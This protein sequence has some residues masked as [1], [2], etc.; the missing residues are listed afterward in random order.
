MNLSRALL[1]ALMASLLGPLVARAEGPSVLP[2]VEGWEG[3]G[4]WRVS[5]GLL[6]GSAVA[7]EVGMPLGVFV[8]GLRR[9]GES[10][11]LLGLRVGFT[12]STE[13]NEAWVLRHEHFIGAAV[14]RVEH[15]QGP[16]L[17]YGQLAAGLMPVS[18]RAR[19][20]QFE[21]L[22]GLGLEDVERSSW[23]VGTWASLE[24]GLAVRIR[25]GLSASVGGGPTLTV[26]KVS[27]L[28]K[29]RWGFQTTLGVSHA[30]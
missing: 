1:I 2:G 30:F 14:A 29:M 6:W 26:Q 16:G 23:S 28:D 19:R 10:P 7:L 8:D 13:S 24:A 15:S 18:E 12:R 22:E 11:V 17:V 9:I 5:G 25:G 4:R 3:P 21:R 20:H 27:G